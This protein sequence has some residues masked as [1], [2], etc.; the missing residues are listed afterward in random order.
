MRRNCLIIRTHWH[1][2]ATANLFLGRSILLR[3][4]KWLAGQRIRRNRGLAPF[5]RQFR[6]IRS[7]RRW[8]WRSFSNRA[9]AGRIDAKR[10]QGLFVKIAR[11]LEPVANLIATNRRSRVRIFCSGNFTV[12]KTLV[13]QGLLYILDRLVGPKW[14]ERDEQNQNC[15]PKFHGDVDVAW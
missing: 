2:F 7:G 13:L 14:T 11:N 10:L 12:I 5:S 6:S 9:R 3:L 1:L 15:D 8:S 4:R